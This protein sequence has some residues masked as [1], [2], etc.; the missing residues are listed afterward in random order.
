MNN[1]I[2][3]DVAK[4]LV[5]QTAG[6]TYNDVAHPTAYATGQILSFIPRTIKVWLGKWEK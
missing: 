3:Q 1:D 4:E 5:S 6:K 2:N